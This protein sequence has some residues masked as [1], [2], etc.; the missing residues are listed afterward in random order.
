M[1][2]RE[3]LIVTFA[4]TTMA[5]MME[6]ACKQAGA[7]GRLIPLPKA[8]DAGCGMAW[9]AQPGDEAALLQLMQERHIKHQLITRV[10]L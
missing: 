7:P 1:T 2:V 9:A 4:A 10:M 3:Y 8:I 6:R 5:L